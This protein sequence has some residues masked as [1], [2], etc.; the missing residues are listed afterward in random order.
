MPRP[1]PSRS[2]ST[3]I[4]VPWHAAWRFATEPFHLTRW[5]P[6]LCRGVRRAGN[7]W[8]VTTPVGDA[9]FRWAIARVPGGL[10]HVVTPPGLDPV[11]VPMR[12]LPRV[13]GCE[14]RLTVER[15]PGTSLAAFRRDQR[16]VAADLAR[17]RRELA[18]RAGIP[19]C[20]CSCCR[21]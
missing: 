4:P 9:G 21:G 1:L 17:L 19:A 3:R 2:L 6:G 13:R 12:V 16:L 18:R 11:R 5:A 15:P 8:R 14:V 20:G 7:R 10:D